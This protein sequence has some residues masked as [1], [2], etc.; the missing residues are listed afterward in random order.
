MYYYWISIPTLFVI[1]IGF[2]RLLGCLIQEY[3]E[4]R[5]TGL[6]LLAI[7]ITLLVLAS[8]LTLTTPL[9][10]V[11]LLTSITVT[12]IYAFYPEILPEF[13]RSRRF[14]LRYTSIAM[15]LSSFWYVSEGLALWSNGPMLA[16][17][18]GATGII[19]GYLSWHKSFSF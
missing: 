19:T 3:L 4:T 14:D 16:V 17:L 18:M 6:A 9:Q 10:L 2:A 7:P 5:S 8:P 13:A 1:T 12:I 11:L 15:L